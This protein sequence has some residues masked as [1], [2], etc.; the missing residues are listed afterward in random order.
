MRVRRKHF[1]VRWPFFGR[2]S[3]STLAA[4]FATQV[5]PERLISISEPYPGNA[6]VWYWDDSEGQDVTAGS[7]GA[8]VRI[9]RLDGR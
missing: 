1:Y 4:E 5:G 6:T 3:A 9:Q 7:T 8:D 2:P